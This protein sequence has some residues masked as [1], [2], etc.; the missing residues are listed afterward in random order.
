MHYNE[1]MQGGEEFPMRKASIATKIYLILLISAV[2]SLIILALSA[3]V[4][5]QDIKQDVYKKEQQKIQVFWQRSLS[6]KFAVGLTNAIAFAKNGNFVKA[7]ETNDRVLALKTANGLVKDLQNFTKFKNIKVHIHD[8]NVHSFLRAWK[9]EKYG[10]NLSGFRNTVLEVK[11]THK[12]L[13]AIEVGKAGP[14]IR[15]LAPLFDKNHRYIGSLEV[16][17]GFNSIGKDA[18]KSL[19]TSMLVLLNTENEDTATFFKNRQK[20]RVANFLI[21]Q[22]EGTLDK[23]F[24]KELSVYNFHDLEKGLVTDSYFVRTYPMKD[25]KGSTIGYVIFGENLSLVNQSVSL[26]TNAFTHQ[27]IIIALLNIIV[28]VIMIFTIN[29]FVKKPLERLIHLVKNLSSGRGDLTKLLPI[30]HHDEITEVSHYINKFITLLN[31][32]IQNTK[33]ISKDNVS[34]SNN[35]LEDADQLSNLSKKQLNIVSDSTQLAQSANED[36]RVTQELAE[37][38]L[39]DVLK[40]SNALLE[41]EHISN[42]VTELVSKNASQEH[43]L[44]YKIKSL[45]EQ[46]RDIQDILDVIKD[47]ADQTNLL[48]LNAAIE[49]ARAGEHGRGFAVVADEVRKLAEKTQHSITTINATIMVVIQT[50][51]DIS[52]EMDQNSEEMHHLTDRT[53]H[54]IEILDTSKESSQQMVVTS[55]ESSKQASSMD[56]KIQKLSLSM[57]HILGVTQ[58][59]E[60]LA[61]ELDSLGKGLEQSSNQLNSKLQEFTTN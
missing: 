5:I 2:V 49:A 30:Q 3:Y 61:Q 26:A 33:N 58:E 57:E 12:P 39:E 9:P 47:I 4:N 14:T 42:E 11:K 53:S 41:L 48:S 52:T 46:T 38:T 17:Q 18:K 44:A 23:R 54:M 36:L 40:S 28:L 59:N 51:Q 7:L 19:H 20:Q 29:I 50:V 27:I 21:A 31:N 37:K 45:V 6:E 24:I 35:I 22:K 55:Q 13:V 8:K 43:E 56:V 34:L 15:G 32:L 10:D 1:K 25:F 16:M 60:K